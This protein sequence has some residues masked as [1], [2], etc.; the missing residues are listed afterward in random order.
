[1]AMIEEIEGFIGPI[2][3]LGVIIP[4]VLRLRSRLDAVQPGH[5]CLS[6]SAVGEEC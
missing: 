3:Y 1:M 4:M 5:A 2:V 6:W